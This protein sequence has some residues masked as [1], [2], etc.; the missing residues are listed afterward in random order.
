MSEVAASAL[1][2]ATPPRCLEVEHDAALV[3][4]HREV[5]VTFAARPATA[6]LPRRLAIRRL[7]LD[8]VGAHVGQERAA[9]RPRDEV[10]QFDD[11]DAG[12]R[13]AH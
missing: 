10:R 9:Q 13:F 8:D 5:V 6:D 2:V 4:V 3:A 7:D 11:A 1:T 12:E